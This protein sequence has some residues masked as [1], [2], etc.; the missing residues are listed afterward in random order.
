MPRLFGRERP[1]VSWAHFRQNRFFL[2][3]DAPLH[4]AAL[5]LG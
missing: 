2:C 3:P 1:F 5:S 4:A